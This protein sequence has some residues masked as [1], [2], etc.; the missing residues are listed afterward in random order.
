MADRMAELMSEVHRMA[1]EDS[2]QFTVGVFQDVEW[3]TAGLE[4]LKKDGFAV[5]SLSVIAK[6]SPDVSNLTKQILGDPGET[7]EVAGLGT[8]RARGP[9]VDALQGVERELTAKGVGACMRRVGFQKHDGYIYQTLT[10]RGGVLVAVLSE[11]RAADALALL[12]A[13]G[14]GNAAIGAWTGR[15]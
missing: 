3:A 6:D 9:I 12:M 10:E 7:V 15:V 8:V 13:Y 1:D 14:G 2:E 11:P 5:E 4:A